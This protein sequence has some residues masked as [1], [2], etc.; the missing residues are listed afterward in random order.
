MPNQ[1]LSSMSKLVSCVAYI[2]GVAHTLKKLGVIDSYRAVTPQV[3]K[4]K[5]REVY[6]DFNVKGGREHKHDSLLL[7]RHVFRES[8][9]AQ[10]RLAYKKDHDFAEAMLIGHYAELVRE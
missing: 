1:G 8:P 7:A 6:P 2:R 4:K 9:R 10:R 3:W 5:M